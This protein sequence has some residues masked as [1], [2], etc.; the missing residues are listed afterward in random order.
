[1][2]IVD[3]AIYVDG[4]RTADPASLDEAFELAG[5]RRGVAW[6]ALDDPTAEELRAVAGE[7]GV[8]DPFV[9]HALAP[10][11]RSGMERLGGALHLVLRPAR[12]DDAAEAVR[13]DE[14]HV[15]LRDDLVVTVRHGGSPD[16][17]AVRARL[18]AHPDRLAEGT[19][20]VLGALL[21]QV[22]EDYAPVVAGLE[23]DIDEIEEQLFGGDEHVS[24]RSYELLREVIRFQKSVHPL[25][26]IVDA[27]AERA[28]EDGAADAVRRAL[29][30]VGGRVRRVSERADAFS[31]LLQ[32]ALTVHSTLVSQ[33]QNEQMEQLSEASVRQAEQSKRIS[34]WAAILFAPTMIA[35]VYGMNFR[36]MPELLLPW[37]YP[38]ALGA[39][40]GVGVLFWAIFK[41]RKWL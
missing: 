31:T 33:R 26:D 8:D 18:E 17:A 13:F 38:A 1:M 21:A 35:A 24:R 20:R 11:H 41:R 19:A 15:L 23:Q 6:V 9:G 5:E 27:L 3:L 28:R 37:G 39:M 10:H 2:P 12:Y 34:A 36:F 40:L 30:A 16:V 32:N 4:R 14:L 25:A 22:V 29:R 7:F